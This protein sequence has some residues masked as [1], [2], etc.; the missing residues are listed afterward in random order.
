MRIKSVSKMIKPY[1]AFRRGDTIGYKFR[2][3]QIMRAWVDNKP[4]Y[5]KGKPHSVVI[6]NEDVLGLVPRPIKKKSNVFLR[7]DKNLFDNSM[8]VDVR[9]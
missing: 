6:D 2:T 7:I 5:L 9:K 4:V 3:S 8:Q 1:K